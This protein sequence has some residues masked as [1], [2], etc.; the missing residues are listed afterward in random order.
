MSLS[1]DTTNL[2]SIRAQTV[3][4]AYGSNLHLAQMAQRCPESR[5]LG[6]GVLHDFQWQINTR[7]FANVIPYPGAC[8]RGLCYLLSQ[9]DER[10]LDAN[11]GVPWAYIKEEMAIEVFASNALISGRRVKEVDDHIRQAIAAW[12]AKYTEGTVELSSAPRKL[13]L[14][15]YHS[16]FS[17]Q[18]TAL[19]YVDRQRTTN[20]SPREEYK[21]RISNGVQDATILGISSE[22][23]DQNFRH[24]ME[25]GVTEVGSIE[26]ITGDTFQLGS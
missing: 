9:N 23:F 22:F 15:N 6:L 21:V 13:S 20:G 5:Y 7:G 16:D 2:P 12:E 26:E 24:H 25:S 19:I 4:F 3:Y 17:V 10:R 18:L 8:V 14:P 11:E 1:N